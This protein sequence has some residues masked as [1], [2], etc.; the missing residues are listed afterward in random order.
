MF[1]LVHAELLNA[2]ATLVILGLASLPVAW[3]LKARL[4][5]F[6]DESTDPMPRIDVAVAHWRYGRW[7]VGSALLGWIP[8]NI[9]VL[10][11]PIWHSLDDA[12]TLRAAMILIM[13]MLQVVAALSVLLVPALV[14]ARFSERLRLTATRAMII[15]F[16]FSLAYV[17]LVIGF[18]NAI[19]HRVFGNQYQFSSSTLW[20]IAI[21]PL[22]TA[23]LGV[24]SSVLRAA[25]RPDRVMWANMAATA[26]TCAI[27]LPLVYVWGVDGALASVLLSLVTT[28]VLAT[29]A[30][31]RVMDTS[32]PDPNGDVETHGPAP[33]T[34]SGGHDKAFRA[35]GSRG[36]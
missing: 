10:A 35:G 3:W 20:M 4:S 27:G 16:C 11:L 8:G 32:S 18:G 12:A 28:V 6:G 31:H 5:R 9:V 21:I 13:P 26:V 15:F 24:S 2:A 22:F 36:R 33:A 19:A 1:A 29:W 14:R 30:G 17:P 34:V 23:I 7:A 25:E